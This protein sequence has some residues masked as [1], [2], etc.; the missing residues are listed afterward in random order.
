[1]NGELRPDDDPY[2]KSWNYDSTGKRIE[3]GQMTIEIGDCQLKDLYDEL[4]KWSHWS[5]LGIGRNLNRGPKSVRLSTGNE[6]DAIKSLIVVV[7]ALTGAGIIVD[8]HLGGN[9]SEKLVALR[10]EFTLAIGSVSG[11][12]QHN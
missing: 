11:A 12:A 7:I 5:I 9:C 10:E 6:N 2:Q 8:N 4:S 1:L 3:I